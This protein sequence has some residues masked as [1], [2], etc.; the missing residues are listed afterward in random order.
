V[1]DPSFSVPAA[2]SG[3]ISALLRLQPPG[4]EVTA[5]AAEASLEVYECGGYL[6]RL[7]RKADR[8]HLLPAVWSEALQKSHRKTAVDN[9][10]ALAELR[11]IGR[12]LTDEKVPFMLLKG[13]AYLTDLYEDPG[14][15]RLTD[16]DL[17]VRH[18]DVKRLARRLAAAG[19]ESVFGDVEFRR[20]E[21]ASTTRGG[22]HFE[23][24][25]WLGRPLR[26]RIP[27]EEIWRRAVPTVLEDVRCLRLDPEDALLYHVVHAADHFFGPSLKWTI[28]LK[29]MLRRWH[30]DFNH[31]LRSATDW[32]LRVA[33]DQALAHLERLFPGDV[34]GALRNGAAAGPIRRGLLG[35]FR[36][37]DPVQLYV[38][39]RGRVSQATLRCLLIDRPVDVFSQ[40]LRVMAR[41]VAGR[42]GRGVRLDSP[43][44]W[45]D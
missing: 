34:P 1:P 45:S 20:F 15:R 24:H 22:V 17:L 3:S 40:T 14:E 23:F 13:G 43:E 7:W 33:L 42:L 30:L 8:L 2:A 35:F 32:R 36:S 26:T 39:D 28:D 21:V 44:S 10:Q 6:Y 38:P 31:L 18:E 4:D 11:A 19:Y 25:W 5:K 37:S 16:I 12:E 41:P 27:Q 29:E 9:L